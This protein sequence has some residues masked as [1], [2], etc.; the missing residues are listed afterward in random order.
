MGFWNVSTTEPTRKFRFMIAASSGL[1][2]LN[3]RWWW[4]TSVQKPKM[5]VNT[6][7]YQLTNHKFNFPGIVTWDPISITMVDPGNQ[8]LMYFEALSL[9]YRPP[10]DPYGST[11][12]GFRKEPDPEFGHDPAEGG[13]APSIDKIEIIQYSAGGTPLETWSLHGAFISGLD[14]GE[15]AYSDDGLVQITLSITYDY[16][17]LEADFQK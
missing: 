1:K 4:A 7:S 9:E 15:L 5:T 2:Q 12:G 6:N 16:A 13:E 14:F 17:T 10:S 11:Y 3:D 8:A